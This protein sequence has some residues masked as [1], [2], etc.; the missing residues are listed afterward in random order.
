MGAP[1]VERCTTDGSTDYDGS[2][3]RQLV[4]LEHLDAYR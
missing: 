1:D 2:L 3:C 4:S